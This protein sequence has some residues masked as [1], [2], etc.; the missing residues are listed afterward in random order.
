MSLD[1]F[2]KEYD[3]LKQEALSARRFLSNAAWVAL[4][5][6]AAT[7]GGAVFAQTNLRSPF[8][9]SELIMVL[10]FVLWFQSLVIT[11]IFLYQLYTMVATGVYIRS[12]L[13]KSG[14]SSSI[15]NQKL[16]SWEHWHQQKKSRIFYV[17]MLFFLQS[18]MVTLFVIPILFN[19]FPENCSIFKKSLNICNIGID[20]YENKIFMFGFCLFL[21]ADIF[22]L[23]WQTARTWRLFKSS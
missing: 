19:W 1:F 4:A 15:L 17:F 7:V 23:I 12:K 18:P 5:G 10:L 22:V 3:A 9:N 14:W 13:S 6:Y 16:P 21:G 20:I 2:L 8:T 11:G